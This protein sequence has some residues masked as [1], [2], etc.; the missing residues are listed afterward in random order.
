MHNFPID[1]ISAEVD[2]KPVIVT[3]K[4]NVSTI[5]CW[6]GHSFHYLLKINAMG[7]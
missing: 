7:I 5:R 1:L 4:K 2:N 3:Q 6:V